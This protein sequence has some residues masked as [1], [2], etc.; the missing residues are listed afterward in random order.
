MMLQLI[1]K[2]LQ[3]QKREKTIFIA[4]F[5][6]LCIGGIFPHNLGL[7]GIQL[8]L[9]VYLLIVYANAYDYKYNAEIMINSLPL[10][11]R[12]VVRAKYLS[13]V[14]FALF[15]LAVSIPVSFAF[16]YFGLAGTSGMNPA[17][18]L[19][20]I[21]IALFLASVYLSI[22]FPIYFKLGYMK[23][24]WANFISFFIIFG[25]IG[26]AGGSGSY[27]PEYG[28]E[29][30]KEAVLN[31]LMGVLAGNGNITLYFILMLAGLIFLIV[32]SQLSVLIYQRKEF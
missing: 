11:R 31:Q 17:V 6:S 15:M 29:L 16:A 25:L 14:I 30:S 1:L 9:G 7:A 13:A 12:H 22:F 21:L 20:F 8:L 32:S 28:D 27:I 2:D 23:S 3:V 5:L 10:A 26:F 19:R 24:R 4:L 18:M